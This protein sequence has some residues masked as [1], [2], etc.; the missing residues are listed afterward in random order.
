MDSITLSQGSVGLENRQHG[1]GSNWVCLCRGGTFPLGPK[2]K[3]SCSACSYD[4][5]AE[6]FCTTVS[7]VYTEKWY[8]RTHRQKYLYIAQ[9]THQQFGPLHT[10]KRQLSWPIWINYGKAA[11]GNLITFSPT[12][13]S[14][15]P[16]TQEPNDGRKPDPSTK[17][18]AH[19]KTHQNR[20]KIVPLL[21][22]L[23]AAGGGGARGAAYNRTDTSCVLQFVS[24]IIL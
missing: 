6:T 10:T 8:Y 12:N 11:R 15:G 24:F 13:I 19:E 20:C 2:K 3:P 16:C 5:S 4:F 7:T 14:V 22:S 17:A 18:S 21:E 9:N 23:A 1:R